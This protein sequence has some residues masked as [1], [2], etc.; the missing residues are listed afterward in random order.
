[1][2]EYKPNPANA[3]GKPAPKPVEKVEEKKEDEVEEE[4]D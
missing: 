4:K 3:G 1:M 2:S